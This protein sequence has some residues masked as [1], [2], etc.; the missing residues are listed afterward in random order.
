MEK[1][2]VYCLVQRDTICAKSG[3]TIK[4]QEKAWWV[5]GVG[6]FKEKPSDA[7][8]EEARRNRQKST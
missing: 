2:P 3:E 8:V 1:A 7:D 4:D 5:I 6:I